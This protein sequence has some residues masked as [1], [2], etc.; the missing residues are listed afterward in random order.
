M[1]DHSEY[2]V[3]NLQVHKYLLLHLRGYLSTCHGWSSSSSLSYKPP[4][5]MCIRRRHH[6]LCVSQSC[7][8]LQLCIHWLNQDS[9]YQWIRCGR[10]NNNIMILATINSI[11]N[12]T[13]IARSVITDRSIGPRLNYYVSLAFRPFSPTHTPTPWNQPSDESK[14]TIPSR[15]S[16]LSKI[17][18]EQIS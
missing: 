6:R 16:Q 18:R 12:M 3:I 8:P 5:N 7:C 13:P 9:L 14:S 11:W 10:F 15:S 2:I 17:T 4:R 1:R